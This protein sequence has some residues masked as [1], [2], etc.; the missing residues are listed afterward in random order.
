[1]VTSF[2]LHQA[3]EYLEQLKGA[4]VNFFFEEW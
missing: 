1:M 3:R 2:T 4:Q